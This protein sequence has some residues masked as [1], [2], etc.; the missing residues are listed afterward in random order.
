MD[1]SFNKLNLLPPD[2][3]RIEAIKMIKLANNPLDP[4]LKDQMKDRV[5]KWVALQSYLISPEY[6]K[7]W[8]DY[9][10]AEDADDSYD[11]SEGGVGLIDD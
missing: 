8:F 2:Y 4:D 3:G 7:K 10:R 5:D 6:D 1:L 9:Q 11:M